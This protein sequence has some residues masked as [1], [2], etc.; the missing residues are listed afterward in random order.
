[1]IAS[2]QVIA[3]S[4]LY[5]T[6]IGQSEAFSLAGE[7]FTFALDGEVRRFFFFFL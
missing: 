3:G 5:S 6:N 7:K 1:L 2:I 4:V